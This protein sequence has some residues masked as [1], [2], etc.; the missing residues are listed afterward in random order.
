MQSVDKQAVAQAFGRAASHYQQHDELQRRSGELLLALKTP[1]PPGTLLDAGC[2]PGSF[3]RRFRAAGHQ[4]TA[5]DLS[6]AM[7]AEAGRQQAADRYITGDIE[8][9]PFADASFD[10]C[11]S[12]LAVQWCSDLRHAVSELM[13]VTRPGG[14]LLFSTVGA[15]SLPEMHRAW[16]GLE[17]SAPVNRFLAQ[18]EMEQ[19]LSGLAVRWHSQLVTQHFVSVPQALQS[20]KGIGATHLHQASRRQPLTRARLE[21]LT[22]HWPRSEAGYALSWQLIFGVTDGG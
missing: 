6:P 10:C 15:A 2:G 21:R 14:Q 13:R 16:Q 8:A 17:E 18:P 9:L 3:S 5:L 22:Q 19:A 1:R 7:L 4:V 11:W 12:N 20:L